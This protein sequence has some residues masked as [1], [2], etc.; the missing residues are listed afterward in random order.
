MTLGR[1]LYFYHPDRRIVH[2]SARRFGTIFVC[3][4][5]FAFIVQAAGALMSS[6]K[7][8]GT[9]NIVMTGLH[10]YMGGIG[11]QEFFILCFTGVLIQL[12]RA[13]IKLEE[14][15]LQARKL[16]SGPIPWRWL[17]YVLYF[18]LFMIT[19]SALGN[20]LE[21]L[22]LTGRRFELSSV[23]LSTLKALIQTTLS[24][25]MKHTSTFSMLR[26]CSWH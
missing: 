15:G 2:I 24:L 26:P 17:F 21:E 20:Q 4:D 11:L 14:R 23:S 18:A 10:V 12:H 19:V 7:D 22:P 6:Q 9:S 3:L 8:S 16:S 5:I 13:L 1:M 25:H